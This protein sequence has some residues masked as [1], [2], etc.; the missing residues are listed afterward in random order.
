MKNDS[1][2][3]IVG[4]AQGFGD[5]SKDSGV[6]GDLV[7][8]SNSKLGEGGGFNAMATR[9]LSQRGSGATKDA[10]IG[11]Y[12][13]NTESEAAVARGL[14]WL[15]KQQKEDG[16][17]R[18]DGGDKTNE[19][20]AAT[21]MALLPFLAAGETHKYGKHY[22]QNVSRGLSYLQNLVGSNG[23]VNQAT[24]MYGHAIATIALCEAVGM[25]RDRSQLREKAQL[26]VNYIV[27]AQATDGSWGYTPGASGDTSIVG[28]QV[29]ALKSAI[30]AELKVD[31]AVLEKAVGFLDRV[32]T[33][34]GSRY[35][36]RDNENT[37]NL[38]S[39]VG[40]L[41]RQYISGWGPGTPGLIKGVDEF[42][43]SGM[44]TRAN[45][46]IYFH[47]YA[48]QVVHFFEG[49]AWHQ[50]WNPAMR[51]LLISLQRKNSDDKNRGSWDA[52]GFSIG[53]HCS[54]LGTTCLSL[55]TLEVYYRHLPLNKRDNAGLAELNR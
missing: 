53:T 46:D 44:P 19:V 31:K 1:D 7:A 15:A 45:F 10:L 2:A 34:S 36:Y 17:W 21:G 22:Q 42:L 23:K 37:T 52:D 12:G 33:D 48:T 35:G 14:I 6:T 20:A 25:T 24:S 41:C 39:S 28:W 30:L 5:P 51:D 29:Q 38:L 3:P 18:Y 47:Y 27:K 54:R 4:M 9:G 50:K 49:P 40:L 11:K 32:S 43:K 26:A 8:N 16:S 55:L 13:G